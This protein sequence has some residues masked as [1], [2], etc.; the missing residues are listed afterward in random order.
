L[1]DS[2][3]RREREGGREGGRRNKERDMNKKSCGYIY[4]YFLNVQQCD[5]LMT[6]T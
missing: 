2:I 4:M 6:L 3:A 5:N 1:K